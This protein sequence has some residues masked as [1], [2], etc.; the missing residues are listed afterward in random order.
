[1]D[2]ET[3][4]YERDGHVV[5]LTYDRLEQRN[6]ISRRMNAELHHAWRRFRDDGDARLLTRPHAS[7]ARVDLPVVST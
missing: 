1:M 5:V 7:L 4:R 6:A 3:L 2:Y